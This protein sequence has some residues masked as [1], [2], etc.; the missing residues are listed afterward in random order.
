MTNPAPTVSARTIAM[1]RSRSAGAGFGQAPGSTWT[2]VSR[3]EALQT[4]A[5]RAL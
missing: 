2:R 3:P 4:A 1:H 5:I